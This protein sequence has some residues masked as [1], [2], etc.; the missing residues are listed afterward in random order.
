MSGFAGGLD[1]GVRVLEEFLYSQLLRVWMDWPEFHYLA[2]ATSEADYLF[3]FHVKRTQCLFLDASSPALLSAVLNPLCPSLL[4][5][6]TCFG[7]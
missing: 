2:I 4:L 5:S 1:V 7:L 3:H 6:L